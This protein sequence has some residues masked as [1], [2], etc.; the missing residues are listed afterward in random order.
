MTGR[1]SPDLRLLAE[2]PS[3]RDSCGEKKRTCSKI[4]EKFNYWSC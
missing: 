3:I 2:D 1:A 4:S